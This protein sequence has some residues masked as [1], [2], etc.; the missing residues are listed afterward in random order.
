LLAA[1]AVHDWKLQLSDA[2]ERWRL[3]GRLPK[4]QQAAHLEPAL[5]AP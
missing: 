3:R 5:Q 2:D 4:G 1:S